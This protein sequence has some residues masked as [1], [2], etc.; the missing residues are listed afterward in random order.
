ML[1]HG[2]CLALWGDIPAIMSMLR[3]SANVFDETVKETQD[4]S[5]TMKKNI[6]ALF[7][8][9]ALC[10]MAA[11]CSD[12]DADTKCPA[13]CTEGCEADGTTCKKASFD[14][15]HT[16]FCQDVTACMQSRD[17]DL[18]N[19]NYYDKN[20][21]S[22]D[23]TLT[24][25]ASC[26]ENA[27]KMVE[28]MADR[29]TSNRCKKEYSEAMTCL[30]GNLCN[31]TVSAATACRDKTD[32]MFACFEKRQSAS[33][34]E[35]KWGYKEF[36]N[37]KA[38]CLKQNGAQF[39]DFYFLDAQGLV[40]VIFRTADRCETEFERIVA[41]NARGAETC[42]TKIKDYFSCVTAQKKLSCEVGSGNDECNGAGQDMYDCMRGVK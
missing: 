30:G 10:V 1:G 12:D 2:T 4:R 36:C 15:V 23:L 11:G 35:D 16:K 42:K 5:P 22:K 41:E 6:F 19:F 14:E 7:A 9:V 28:D 27:D 38:E 8:T 21:K 33:T 13:T 25:M 39:A 20:Y 32:A 31:S 18:L 26:M 3:N 34:I 29:E 37:A 24:N 17:T 40:S